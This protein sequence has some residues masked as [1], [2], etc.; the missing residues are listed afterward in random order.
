M[1][2]EKI[3][4]KS[5]NTNYSGRSNFQPIP[6]SAYKEGSSQN[7]HEKLFLLLAARLALLKPLVLS[8]QNEV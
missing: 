4:R 2:G 5:P 6:S 8:R 1:E 7:A 3:E